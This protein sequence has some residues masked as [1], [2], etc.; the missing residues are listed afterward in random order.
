MTEEKVKCAIE[1]NEVK[2]TNWEKF[3]HYGIVIYLSC[4]E[5]TIVVVSG[6]DLITKWPRPLKEGEIWFLIIPTL[7]VLLSYKLQR[8]KLQFKCVETNLDL[9]VLK[10]IIRKVGK[11]LGWSLHKENENIFIAKTSPGFFSGSWGEQ[12]TIIIDQNKVLV[13]SICDP[14]KNSSITS[15]GRNRKNMNRL[16]DEIRNQTANTL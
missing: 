12:I 10:T 8:K 15:M 6:Y 4:L 11:E 3:T 7:L 9:N 2:L 1:T 14:E 5:V 16:I 13:N